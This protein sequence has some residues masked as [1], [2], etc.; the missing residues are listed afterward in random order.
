[1]KAK[2]NQRDPAAMLGFLKR[3][4]ES[5]V[6][7]PSAG[8]ALR[9]QFKMVTKGP[10]RVAKAVVGCDA[11]RC[12]FCGEFHLGHSRPKPLEAGR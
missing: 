5:K 1:M 10:A 3:V 11:Y 8:N 2:F 4:C 7:Y 12:Q 9:A 6:S